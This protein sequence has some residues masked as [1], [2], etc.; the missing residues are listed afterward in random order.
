M[1]VEVEV[2][3]IAC[4]ATEEAPTGENCHWWLC[5][6]HGVHYLPTQC[7]YVV[8]YNLLLHAAVFLG[9]ISRLYKSWK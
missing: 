9:Q 4:R 3:R 1:V 2:W 6:S 8:L 7:T 5:M